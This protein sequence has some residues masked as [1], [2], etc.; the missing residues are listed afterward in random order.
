MSFL[1]G[2]ARRVLDSPVLFWT[3]ALALA[4]V[5]ALV[6]TR[7]GRP[8]PVDDARHVVVAQRDIAAGASLRGAV[9]VEP[10]LGTPPSDALGSLPHPDATATA[11]IAAGEPVLARRVGSTSGPAAGL[12]TGMRGVFVPPPLG[13]IA[14]VSHVDV[15][16]SGDPLLGSGISVVLAQRAPVLSREPDALLVGL[17]HAQSLEVIEALVSGTVTVTLSGP[18]A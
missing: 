6:L 13:A 17:T 7:A 1:W 15:V 3:I 5:S 18:E 16:G 4:A 9:A 12:Q 8:E 11:D 10:W 2:R 14:E